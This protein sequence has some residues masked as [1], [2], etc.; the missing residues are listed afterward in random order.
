M[1]WAPCQ[2]P[3]AFM[4]VPRP[5][6]ERAMST[7]YMVD[8]LPLVVKRR[9]SAPVSRQTSSASSAWRASTIPLWV[10]NPSAKAR[11]RADGDDLGVVAEDVGHVALPEI[12]D[13]VAVLVDDPTAVGFGDPWREG[14]EQP[15][16]VAAAVDEVAAGLLVDRGRSR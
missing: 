3:P 11:L 12:E 10:P 1:G 7:A 16:G 5:V 8:R 6:N 9:R 4:T 13:P 14:F 15:D 2:P